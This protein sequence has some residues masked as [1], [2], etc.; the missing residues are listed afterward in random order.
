MSGE[1]VAGNFIPRAWSPL[2]SANFVLTACAYNISLRTK[3]RGISTRSGIIL[4]G[5]AGWAEVSPFLEYKVPYAARWL[6]GAVEQAVYGAPEPLRSE[7]P[8]NVTIPVVSP[9]QAQQIAIQSGALSAKV[10]VVEEGGS[11]AADLSRLAA[12]REALGERAR[13]R[14]D[15]NGKWDLDT[16]LLNIPRYERAAGGLEYIEQ[17][18]AQVEDLAAVR[19][20]VSVP[21]AADESLR[22]SVDPLE[23]RRLAA[24]DIAVIKNQP[25]GGVRA[26]LELAAKLELPA[27]LSSALETSVGLEAGLACAA[28]LP[29]LSYACGLGTID[30]FTADVTAHSLRARHGKIKLQK[31]VPEN[32]AAVAAT[33]ELAVFWQDRLQQMWEYLRTWKIFGREARY[34]WV[35]PE[36]CGLASE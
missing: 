4:H 1:Y 27:V 17:P 6:I 2:A 21:I 28:A 29:Q 33:G 35:T 22:R 15:V 8:V 32:L 10:K 25:L 14:I 30:L 34:R 26:A 31:I 24:A 11:R 13:I 20:R 19:R 5:P 12:V 16:A 36:E 7:I 3:F 9:T 23:V 18:C